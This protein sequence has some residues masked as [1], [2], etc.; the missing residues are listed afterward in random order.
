MAKLSTFSADPNQ[1]VVV[2]GPPKAGKTELVGGL[3][4]KYKLIWFDLENGFETL[5]KLPP[6]YQ[7]NIELYPLPDSKVFP[8]AV[9]TMLKVFSGAKV[10]I[11]E[12]HGKVSCAICNKDGKPFH[13]EFSLKEVPSD[14]IVVVDSLTQFT[15]SALA[16][17]T[18]NQNDEYKLQ[19][20][21]WGNLRTLVE[22]LLSC[23]QTAPCKIVAITH[24]EE[25]EMEDGRKKIVPVC[26]SSKSSRNTAKFFGHVVYCEVKNKQ[27]IA[28]SST[29]YMNNI[30]TGSRTDV[31]LEKNGTLLSIFEGKA[32]QEVPKEAASP[33]TNALASFKAKSLLNQSK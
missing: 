9:E 17:I 6:E 7:A 5:L 26:G 1:K 18:K 13:P 19:F 14:T 10:K 12:E 3:A 4:A 16:H 24:E 29:T 11:C 20:D 8:I 28:A 31:A 2:Y 32:A 15:I 30:I 33:A 25:V 22:K 21:D 23:I 27:H